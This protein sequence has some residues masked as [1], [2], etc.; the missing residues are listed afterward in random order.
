MALV[1]NLNYGSNKPISASGKP[2]IL[3]YRSDNSEYKSGDVLRIEI[4]TGR[5]GQHAFPQDSYLEAKISVNY[6]SLNNG[7][8]NI[9]IDQNAYSLFRRLRVLHGSNVIEDTLYCNRIWQTIYDI[10]RAP[11]FRSSDKINLL[12]GDR[13]TGSGMPFPTVANTTA[14][15]STFDFCFVIPSALLGCL[16][17]KAIPLSLCGASS[18]YLELELESASQAFLIED[19]T[20][21]SSINYFTLSEIYYNAKT[22]SLP[23]DIE[24]AI[25]EE[26]GGIMNLPAVAY[27]GELKTCSA[28][29]GSFNDKFAFQH[30]S[31]KNFL[32]FMQNSVSTTASNARSITQ[33]PSQ[34]L[35]E[36]NLLLNGESYPSQPINTYSKMYMELL[37]SFDM[38]TDTNNGGFIDRDEYLAENSATVA[39]Q[40]AD[41]VQASIE[42]K[43]FVAGIDLDRFNHSSDLL[44]SGTNTVGNTVNLNLLFGSDTIGGVVFASPLQQTNIYA[45]IQY[46]LNIKL[47]NGLL[48][49]MY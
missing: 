28:N 15:T 7:A 18:I 39:G 45:F 35:R 26:S 22:V 36:W 25:I 9:L 44:M 19:A 29:S 48:Q 37:R 41:D 32:F 34:H 43:R 47:Q 46:D 5:Q 24:K 21:V 10:Q 13:D 2:E 1:K 16:A 17:T 40:L 12:Y 49:A 11:T 4:P 6:T 23:Y 8:S 27:K 20:K 31:I 42:I 33:R 38:M 3:R 14:N 30:S